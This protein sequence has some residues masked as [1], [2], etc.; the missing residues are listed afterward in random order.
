M[1]ELKIMKESKLMKNDR[2]KRK[3]ENFKTRFL[4]EVVFSLMKDTSL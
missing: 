1:E 4:F 3:L 2:K